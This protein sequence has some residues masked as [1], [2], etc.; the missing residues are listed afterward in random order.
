MNKRLDNLF[1]KSNKMLIDKSSKIVLMSDCHRGI[2]DKNDNFLKNESIYIKALDYYYNNNFTYIELGDGDELWE[3]KDYHDIVNKH[4]DTFKYLKKFYLSNRFIMIYGNHD[5]EKK[6]KPL[7]FLLE[8]LNVIESL[9]L[10]YQDMD[11]FLIHGHQV[12]FIN[13]ELW[14]ISRFLVRNIWKYLER[15]GIKH[16][17]R[18]LKTYKPTNVVEKKL[19]K[20]SRKRNKIIIAGHTHKPIFPN[21]NDMYFN[22]GSCIYKTGITSIE[23]ENGMISLVKWEV[24]NEK[25]IKN[26]I[27][28]PKKIIDYYK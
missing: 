12:D 23:I 9:I 2:A 24:E 10:T 20:W 16:P 28:G 6:N 15:L 14:Y 18:P 17:V 11:I 3:V 21:S 19:T 22:D 4:L 1:F 7:N 8:D 25:V 13:N 5:L 27:E 26:V